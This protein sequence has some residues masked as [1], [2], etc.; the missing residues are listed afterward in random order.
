MTKL[1]DELALLSRNRKAPARPPWYRGREQGLERLRNCLR[2]RAHA[3]LCNAT[4]GF[5]AGADQADFACAMLGAEGLR[6]R[7]VEGGPTALLV[8]EWLDAPP[9]ALPLK[10]QYVVDVFWNVTV[11]RNDDMPSVSAM[12]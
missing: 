12:G 1:V 8:V 6:C 2:M 7:L 10:A 4:F 5:V 3:S 9:P 11:V